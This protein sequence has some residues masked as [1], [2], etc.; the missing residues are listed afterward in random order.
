MSSAF[1]LAGSI[2]VMPWG[3][4]GKA[5]AFLVKNH[6]WLELPLPYSFCFE[7]GCNAPSCGSRP[8]TVGWQ[9]W[10]EGQKNCGDTE[11]ERT[12]ARGHLCP[13]KQTNKHPISYSLHSLSTQGILVCCFSNLHVN[14][15]PLCLLIPLLGM[16]SPLIIASLT[17]SPP[18][19]LCSDVTLSMRLSLTLCSSPHTIFKI[20]A[21]PSSLNFLT[22][23]PS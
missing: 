16:L 23:F 14:S 17:L 7:C 9:Q 13:N 12:K 21:P 3:T 1:L 18:L 22:Q 15:G 8:M 20:E 10:V 19:Y 6:P 11:P 2:H 4:S 5:F